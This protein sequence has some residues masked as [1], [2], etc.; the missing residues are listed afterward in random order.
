MVAEER[1]LVTLVAR[2]GRHLQRYSGTG[3]RLVVGC[4]PYRFVMGKKASGDCTDQA[5]EVLVISSQ[6]GFDHG[7]MFPKGRRDMS[8]RILLAGMKSHSKVRVSRHHDSWLF[9][10]KL[11]ILIWDSTDNGGPGSHLA[12]TGGWEKDESIEAAA[13]REALEEAGVRGVAKD[14]LG[15]WSFKSKRHGTYYDGFMFPLLVTEQLDRWPE[16]HVRHQTTVIMLV[17]LDR[18]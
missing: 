16:D 17:W 3:R 8:V 10:K 13:C 14:R 6:K 5:I 11:S 4:I 15:K 9:T 18:Q 7:I 12:T 1:D 2:T